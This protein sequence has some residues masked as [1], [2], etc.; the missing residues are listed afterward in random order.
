[1]LA[2]LAEGRL[3]FVDTRTGAT[4]PRSAQ[5]TEL[6]GVRWSPDARHLLTWG[7]DSLLRVWD[8]RSGQEVARRRHFTD[9]LEATFSRDGRQVLVPDGS[10]R[11]ETLDA[12]TLQPLHRPVRLGTGVSTLVAGVGDGAVLVASGDGTLRRIDPMTGEVLAE[13]SRAFGVGSFVAS[14]DG[15][16]VAGPDPAGVMRLFDARTL[17]W[18]GPASGAPWGEDRD[19]A[20]DGRQVAAVVQG[21]VSLWDGR[22]GAYQASL[23]VDASGPLSIAYLADGS[24]LVVAAADGRT[25]TVDTRVGTWVRRACALAGR[26]LSHAEWQLYFPSRAYRKTCPGLPVSGA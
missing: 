6:W 22:S 19:Y 21:R 10:G 5:L 14:P 2:R 13:R 7:Q 23:P 17:E 4:T 3:S 26:N 11:L 20:P 18:V 15:R 25:W 1:V 16:L 12:T 8:A 24:G 9:S